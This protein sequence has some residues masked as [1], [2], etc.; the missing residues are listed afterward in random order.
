MSSPATG[1]WSAPVRSSRSTGGCCRSA[2]L[3]ES[4]LTGR[5]A[6]GRAGTPATIVRSGVVNAGG[7]IDLVATAAAAE[8]TYAGVVRLVEQA[9]ASSAPFVRVADR[10]AVAFVPLT[11][12]SPRC[13]LVRAAADP[14]RA[15]AVLVVATPCPL[16]LAA[17]IAIMS[18]LSRAAQHRRGRQGRRRP[19]T[20]RRRTGDAVRQD[21]HA[22]PGPARAGRRRSP[23]AT[24]W[25]PTSCCGS[26]HRSTR[27]RRTCWPARSSP[28]ATGAGWHC[29]CRSTVREVH[30][31]G[32]E[33]RVGGHRS[34]SAR[35][36]GSSAS[37][38]RRGRARCAGAPT[39]TAR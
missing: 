5:A 24:D 32:V 34:G 39:W 8:S 3:D 22:D 11:L 16:L 1:C 10:F 7:P 27:S 35:R 38:S 20:P 19:R 4:A 23:P 13:S 37:T 29:R 6:A 36:R 26:R 21:R 2:V 9:Q 17:P 30:G 14:V 18:G 28:P 25:T 15:V 12:S 31:Y 33:G